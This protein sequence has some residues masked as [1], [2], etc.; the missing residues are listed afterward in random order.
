MSRMVAKM[1]CLVGVSVVVAALSTVPAADPPE[2]KSLKLDHK[3]LDLFGGPDDGWVRFELT[4]TISGE[5]GEGK[6]RI[7]GWSFTD[8]GEPLLCDLFGDRMGKEKSTSSEHKITL[9][10]VKSEDDLPRA[11]RASDVVRE[12]KDKNPFADP[13][14][15]GDRKIYTVEGL[16]FG[17]NRGLILMVSPSGV[18]RL[19]YFGRYGGPYAA[20]LEPRDSF[21]GSVM[22]DK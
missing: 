12:R 8:G 5:R 20:T 4:A 7:T 15:K 14:P 21:D 13:S 6:L 22:G 16:D 11:R 9:K 10:L 1:T 19:I 2:A 18:H 17:T 3:T